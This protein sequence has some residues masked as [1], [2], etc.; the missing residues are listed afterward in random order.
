MSQWIGS[1]SDFHEKNEDTLLSLVANQK[2]FLCQYFLKYNAIKSHILV[3]ALYSSITND[4][5]ETAKFIGW[6]IARNVLKFINVPLYDIWLASLCMCSGR[7]TT[8]L[9]SFFCSTNVTIII[10]VPQLIKDIADNFEG[11]PIKQVAYHCEIFK[12]AKAISKEST[13][14]LENDLNIQCH[15]PGPLAEQ[16]FNNHR[17]LTLVCPS[18]IKSKNFPTVPMFL[19]RSCIQVYC[20]VKGA[21]PIGENHFPGELQGI[22]TD[23]IERFSRFCSNKLRI[24]DSVPNTKMKGTLGGFCRFFGREAF[25]T[26]AHTMM[27]WDTLLSTGH[28]HHTQLESVRFNTGDNI[29]NETPLCGKVVNHTFTHHNPRTIST[30]AAV[31]ELDKDISVPL[32]DYVSTKGN[33]SLHYTELGLKSPFLQDGY[34]QSPKELLGKN[35][36]VVCARAVSGFKDHGSLISEV[37]E[38][39]MKRAESTN[40]VDMAMNY[41]QTTQVKTSVHMKSFLEE[42]YLAASQERKL[43]FYN[44]LAVHN[45]PFEQ[46]DSGACAYITDGKCEKGSLGM[47]IADYPGG[48]CIVTPMATVLEKLGLI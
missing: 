46:G 30:D 34:I 28:K 20:Y 39:E 22:L 35:V 27:D 3:N 23:V 9:Y 13:K 36:K 26:C 40:I 42:F 43:T 2:S 16:L 18:E 32:D 1:Q 48:G 47:A 14:L 45:T 17:R 11:I 29:L 44:Q 25:L 6:Q 37:S 41:I 7:K 33:G 24:G 19:T 21:I 5:A 8:K 38:R 31:I 10:M 12:E 15:V 4:D